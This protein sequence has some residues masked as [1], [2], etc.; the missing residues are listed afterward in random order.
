MGASA[1]KDG[2]NATSW[3]SN[4]S[5]TPSEISDRDSPL[6]TH[7]R[8]LRPGSGGAGRFR[9]GLGQD[10]LLENR[11]ETPLA[12]VFLAERVRYAAPG[13]CGGEPGGLG[14]VRINGTSVGDTKRQVILG[15]GDTIL[16]ST[17]GGGGYG[18]PGERSPDRIERDRA[19]G[20]I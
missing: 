17:P 19:L 6:F 12:V 11:H 5:S 3:P 2:E 4:I 18:E 13:A 16:I 20:Y 15:E 9:G 10:V 14:D 7:Y 8:Q 1:V